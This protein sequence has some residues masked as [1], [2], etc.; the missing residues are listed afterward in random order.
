MYR[1]SNNTLF[2]KRNVLNTNRYGYRVGLTMN[3]KY[4][5]VN[6]KEEHLNNEL[7]GKVDEYVYGIKDDFGNVWEF[8]HNN[9]TPDNIYNYS[10]RNPNCHLLEDFFY[11]TEE[12]RELQLSK[13][14]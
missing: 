6:S 5:I 9:A 2:C 14:I 12:Y 1:L 11:T 10:V 3:K 4:E 8:Y 13:L 7:F